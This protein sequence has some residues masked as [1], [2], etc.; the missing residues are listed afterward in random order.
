MAGNCYRVRLLLCAMA[1]T[2]YPCSTVRSTAPLVKAHTPATFTDPHLLLCLACCRSGPSSW[3]AKLL[4]H[5]SRTSRTSGTACLQKIW[6]WWQQSRPGAKSQGRAGCGSLPSLCEVQGRFV[7]HGGRKHCKTQGHLI[8]L[9][10]RKGCNETRCFPA[11][12]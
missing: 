3:T 9:A 5:G 4:S 12:K 7:C 8:Q 6:P 1:G 10:H 2:M 11:V